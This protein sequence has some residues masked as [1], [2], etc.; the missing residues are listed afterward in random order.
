MIQKD[1]LKVRGFLSWLFDKDPQ[2]YLHVAIKK[3]H[4]SLDVDDWTV[5]I[6]GNHKESSF[7]IEAAT[8]CKALED[9]RV[10]FQASIGHY[11]AGTTEPD[12]R[13]AAILR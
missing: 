3:T 2:P 7:I 12:I 5:Y 11:D 9:M 13:C 1:A 10:D 4:S 6:Y 8:L